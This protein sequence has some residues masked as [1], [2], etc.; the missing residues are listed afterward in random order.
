LICDGEKNNESDQTNMAASWWASILSTYH[1]FQQ[2]IED[3]KSAALGGQVRAHGRSGKRKGRE[4][5][6]GVYCRGVRI[7]QDHHAR[8]FEWKIDTLMR[9]E[10]NIK[11]KSWGLRNV[12]KTVAVMVAHTSR[13][14]RVSRECGTRE[15]SWDARA[16][17]S[18][19]RAGR[20]RKRRMSRDEVFPFHE[21]HRKE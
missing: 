16:P 5:E 8:T 13:N 21:S 11:G 1:E 9:P 7:K 2:S 15:S 14:S 20:T 10:K 12:L 3:G 18:R 17:K 4:T 19:Q 6:A